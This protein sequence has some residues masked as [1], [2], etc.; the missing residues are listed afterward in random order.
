MVILVIVIETTLATEPRPPAATRPPKVVRGVIW[1]LIRLLTS[2][3]PLA[4]PDFTGIYPN[5]KSWWVEIDAGGVPQRELGFD[6]FG[7]AIVAGPIGQNMGFWTDSHMVFD[8]VEHE[9]VPNDV[10][11]SAWLAFE[12]SHA[13]IADEDG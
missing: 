4:N 12:V 11:E 5:V 7:E 1:P 8:A 6:A 9:V 13:A 3:I 2:V 10:F